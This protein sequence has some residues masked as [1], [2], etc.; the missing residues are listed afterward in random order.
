MTKSSFDSSTLSVKTIITR[1]RWSRFIDL[2]LICACLVWLL[3][4]CNQENLGLL[5]M[6]SSHQPMI[7][8]ADFKRLWELRF[9][10][11]FCVCLKRSVSTSS[12]PYIFASTRSLRKDNFCLSIIMLM[13]SFFI[14]L[15]QEP[16]STL[17]LLRWPQTASPMRPWSL[18]PSSLTIS[19]R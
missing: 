10:Q 15:V 17:P 13:C 18:P 1:L 6:S 3:S 9:L 8:I 14:F 4:S 2:N 12:H 19:A 7:R 16:L 11:S 5:F